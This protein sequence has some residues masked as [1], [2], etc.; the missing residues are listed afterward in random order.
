MHIDQ[1]LQQ[2]HE[3]QTKEAAPALEEVFSWMEPE[4]LIKVANG[5]ATVDEVLE[6]MVSG[7]DKE[8]RIP[9]NR[10][11]GG[12]MAAA[13][14]AAIGGVEYAA[15]KKGKRGVFGDYRS[16]EQKIKDIEKSGEA[17]LI[18]MDKIARQIAR[19]HYEVAQELEKEAFPQAKYSDKQKARWKKNWGRALYGDDPGMEKKDEFS[20]PEAQQKAK[21]MQ[22]AM[23][24]TK[25]APAKVRKAAV[26]QVG[27]KIASIKQAAE[28]KKVRPEKWTTGQK[29]YHR[30]MKKG[31]GVGKN[32]LAD[33][34]LVKARLKRGLPAGVAG[35]VAGGLAGRKFLGP[36]GG[37]AG[38]LLGSG[39]GIIGGSA[40]GEGKYLKGKGVKRRWMGLGSPDLTPAA[41]EKYLK[42]GESRKTTTTKTKI[43]SIQKISGS[44]SAKKM[45]RMEDIA[46]RLS[47]AAGKPTRKSK[48]LLQKAKK[49]KLKMG[50]QEKRRLRSDSPYWDE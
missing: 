45:F 30:A 29:V 35:G 9:I 37:V 46:R 43:S 6:R 7:M 18:F 31:K 2:C 26:K 13:P 27:T 41:A 39:L 1:W 22:T 49:A 15:K 23:K 44:L 50:L 20:S 10:L 4:D 33:P 28:E 24:A 8:A 47:A 36:G 25:G 32:V 48:L 34:E 19:V 42:K 40:S 21:V 12:A 17:K 11:V 38:A 5:E 3:E 14:V 16:K